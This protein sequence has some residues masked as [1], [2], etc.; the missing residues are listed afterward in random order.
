VALLAEIVRGA[1]SLP[2]AACMGQHE[3][4]DESPGSGPKYQRGRIE[5][6]AAC[7]AGCPVQA[8]CTAV[9]TS[10]AISIPLAVGVRRASAVRPPGVILAAN[11]RGTLRA[12][13]ITRLPVPSWSPGADR[14]DLGG[15]TV[16]N[17]AQLGRSFPAPAFGLCWFQRRRTPLSRL[18]GG[19][20]RM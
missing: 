5:R 12:Q 2:G 19:V 9:V 6:A 16:R 10:G 15:T 18:A 8:K 3:L 1:P 11:R 13:L 20:L 14:C 17:V 7:C 4:Y